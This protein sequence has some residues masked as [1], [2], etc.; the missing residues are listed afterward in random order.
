[1]RSLIE[2]LPAEIAKRIHQDWQ[3]NEAEYWAQRDTVLG[4]YAEQW[5]GFAEG[6]T[7]GTETGCQREPRT[8]S[9]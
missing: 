2:G 8:R 1:M 4:Q 7:W 3:K 6:P 5:I 9:L